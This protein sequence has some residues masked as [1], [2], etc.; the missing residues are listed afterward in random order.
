MRK[1]FNHL[2]GSPGGCDRRWP[3]RSDRPDSQPGKPPDRSAG[4]LRLQGCKRLHDRRR[5]PVPNR[6]PDG[7]RHGAGEVHSDEHIGE[8]IY[9]PNP[10]GAV[11]ARELFHQHQFRVGEGESAVPVFI[12]L[13][14]DDFVARAG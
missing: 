7:E 11:S 10:A 9:H 2:H 13:A 14:T 1:L 5:N 6:D 4:K 12:E 3:D 8:E